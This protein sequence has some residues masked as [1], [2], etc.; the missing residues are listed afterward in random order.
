MKRNAI[1]LC[2]MAFLLPANSHADDG[3]F[4]W[5][6]QPYGFG[7][8][9]GETQFHNMQNTDS[10]SPFDVFLY[11]Q[12]S[13]VNI[14]DGFNFEFKFPHCEVMSAEILNYSVLLY[15]ADI[16][17]RWDELGTITIDG[18]TIS[19]FSAS[20][21]GDGHG[22][23]LSNTGTSIFFDEGFDESA[24]AFLIGKATIQGVQTQVEYLS[25]A[26]S[27]AGAE[28]SPE[29]QASDIEAQGCVLDPPYGAAEQSFELLPGASPAAGNYHCTSEP[30]STCDGT[31]WNR[32]VP[33]T[34]GIFTCDTFGSSVYDT[35]LEIYTSNSAGVAYTND[36]AAGSTRSRISFPMEQ[37]ETYHIRIVS[38][39]VE[40]KPTRL[41]Y[42]FLDNALPGDADNDGEVNLLDVAPFVALISSGEYVAQADVNFDGSIDLLDVGPF[43]DILSN[44]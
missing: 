5:S 41:A 3:V 12:P 27:N 16:G 33:T 14:S 13:T 22:I 37:G 35:Q 39:P 15:G 25:A 18:D 26:V 24:V 6:T 30:Q 44:P 32:F 29:L 21:L 7:A 19:G 40:Y 43:V 2:L 36:D 42:T 28:I 17:P 1:L 4:F 23:S 34:D 38:N 20:G 31:V 9:A 11:Y 10:Q 8:Q